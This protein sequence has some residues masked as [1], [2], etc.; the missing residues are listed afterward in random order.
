[1][2]FTIT[3]TSYGK[4]LLLDLSFRANMPQYDRS[5]YALRFIGS[6]LRA[7]SASTDDTMAAMRDSGRFLSVDDEGGVIDTWRLQE[8]IARFAR[9]E[10]ERVDLDTI[11][12]RFGITP[13][14]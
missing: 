14:K 1:M 7:S 9:G 8:S 6:Y 3:P 4:P 5:G 13:G 12:E 11:R 2:T 10:G